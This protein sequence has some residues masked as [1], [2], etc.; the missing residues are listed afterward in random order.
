[1]KC[2][3]NWP[4]KQN[5]WFIVALLF[6]I[7]FQAHAITTFTVNGAKSLT[8]DREEQ[9]DVTFKADTVSPGGSLSLEIYPDFRGDGKIDTEDM[10][11]WFGNVEKLVVTDGVKDEWIGD[12]DGETNSHIATTISMAEEPFESLL[13]PHIIIRAVDEDGS[14][15]SVAIHIKMPEPEQTVSGRVTDEYGSPVEGVP[16]MGTS[17]SFEW[18]PTLW[19]AVTNAD[20][21]YVLSL[22]TGMVTVALGAKKGYY[23]ESPV[24]RFQLAEGEHK[25][26]VN[27]ELK[28]DITPPTIKHEPPESAII[29]NSLLLEAVIEDEEMGESSGDFEE[30]F[31]F[32]DF[33]ESLGSVVPRVY[34]RV[35]GSA[36]DFTM[37]VM[38]PQYD[39]ELPV[40]L[41]PFPMPMPEFDEAGDEDDGVVAVRP[42]EEVGPD[43]RPI[44]WNENRYQLLI[45]ER[46]ITPAGLEYYIEAADR[47]NNLATSPPDAPSGLHQ[48]RAQESPYVISGTVSRPDGTGVADVDIYARAEGGFARGMDMM[49]QAGAASTK[50]DADGKYQ[51]LLA[52]PGRWYLSIIIPSKYYIVSPKEIGQIVQVEEEKEYTGCDWIIVEDNQPPVIEHNPDTDVTASSVGE[53]V[54]IKANISDDSGVAYAH[55]VIASEFV[56]HEGIPLFETETDEDIDVGFA[57]IIAPPRPD[58]NGV[59]TFVIP[60]YRVTGDI[61]YFIEAFDRVGN[62]ATHPAEN[63]KEHPH[64][65]DIKPAPYTIYGRVTVDGEGLGY[66]SITA[67][68]NTGKYQKTMTKRDGTFSMAVSEGTWRIQQHAYGYLI[69]NQIEPVVIETEG[70]YEVNIELTRDKNP[71]IIVH[72]PETDVT[73]SS[74]GKD[75]VI[76]ATITDETRIY[77]RIVIVSGIPQPFYE[78]YED[79]E[80]RVDDAL[81]PETGSGDIEVGM[82]NNIEPLPPSDE[83]WWGWGFSTEVNGDVYTFIIPG[84]LVADDIEYFIEARDSVCLERGYTPAQDR[85]CGNVATHPAENPKEHPH[86]IDIKP[87]PYTIYGKITVDGEGLAYVSITAESDT[88]EYKKTMTKWD[89]TFSMAASE[90]TWRIQQHAYGYLLVNQ[91]EPVVIEAKGQYEVNIALA[92][93]N[94][95]PIIVHNPET[96]VTASSAGEDIT[97]KATIT[98]ETNT[99]ARIAIV[100]GVSQPFYGYDGDYEWGIDD[101]LPPEIK[102]DVVEEAGIGVSEGEEVGELK[103]PNNILPPD[104][105]W[106]DWRFISKRDGDVYTFVIPGHLVMGDIEYFIEVRDSGGNVATHPAEHP[107]QNP[108]LINIK[109][110]PYAIIGKVTLETADGKGLNSVAITATSDAGDYRKTMTKEDGTF[111]LPVKPGTWKIAA[112]MFGMASVELIQPVVVENEGEYE[113][114]IVLAK[115][116]KPPIIIHTP[117][118]RFVFGESM[119]ITVSVTDD[120]EMD[121]VLIRILL[122][123]EE[124][125]IKAR[126]ATDGTYVANLFDIFPQFSVGKTKAI[127]YNVEATDVAGNSVVGATYSASLEIPYTISGKVT[128]DDQQQAGV[129]IF[130]VNE[131]GKSLTETQADGSYS[132]P[133]TLGK[134][135]VMVERGQG[136]VATDGSSPERD[137]DVEVDKQY[138]DI[139]FDLKWTGNQHDGELA[140]DE[141]IKQAWLRADVISDQIIDISDLVFIGK[142]FG[143]TIENAP[144]TGPNPDING[145]GVVDISDLVFAAKHFGETLFPPTAPLQTADKIKALLQVVPERN[146][147]SA[148]VVNLILDADTSVYGL[149]FDLAVQSDKLQLTALTEGSLLKRGGNQTFWIAPELNQN[150]AQ[151]A[152]ISILAGEERAAKGVLAQIDLRLK[153]VEFGDVATITLNNVTL[154]DKDG[155][156]FLLDVPPV[157]MDLEALALPER[158]LLGQNYPNPFNPETWL[159]YQI[160]ADTDVM[161]NIYNVSGQLVRTLDLGRKTPGLY[162]NQNRAAHW[163]GRNERGEQVASG[164]YFYAICAGKFSAVKRMAIVK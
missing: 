21:E 41:P 144:E 122:G 80:W 108:H 84:D 45:P 14:S 142:H 59:Y 24:K 9:I 123:G 35:K 29:N 72:N 94:N 125:P 116:E 95:P 73:A 43:G 54:I 64:R 8:V 71:P 82:L 7:T 146:D 51:L 67:E 11:A 89:G 77:A 87:A 90:G 130:F 128:V 1:M 132:I 78:Y 114:D 12:E 5:F 111:S 121:A 145:D 40:P 62:V 30:M 156:I 147:G 162:F 46:Y 66:V 86:R 133:A 119:M 58:K 152:A 69:V 26:E 38:Y 56:S 100:S 53:D 113:V 19:T 107:S 155:N 102:S 96:D 126:P 34:F 164:V 44:V 57:D 115:D 2:K 76:K 93:D 68:S 118:A 124:I 27:F 160:T 106:W 61:E 15:D 154:V 149:Q 99:Y 98:D 138:T 159:P 23:S 151:R 70:Q 36:E 134:N 65:I 13:F 48:V 148:V 39:I 33:P 163:D 63:P 47:A 135:T 75:V 105:I 140:G 91:M 143:E 32:F 157:K 110:A 6:L 112:F 16:V 153:D 127:Q 129:R 3:N 141:E 49:E 28:V 17:V 104:E 79:G 137:I 131:A 18:Q 37:M 52:M 103:P 74:A 161:I 158:N 150:A 55:V 20:G 81:P 25:T 60:S 50:T 117:L 120:G 22:D 97:I 31:K 4:K 88:G 109:P 101:A 42:G 92:R 136:Y 139:N 10:I 83:I 85:E